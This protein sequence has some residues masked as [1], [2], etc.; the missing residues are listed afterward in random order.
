MAS[1]LCIYL[2][3]T[4]QV[5]AQDVF[6]SQACPAAF[7]QLPLYPNASLCQI[8][9]D[10]LPASLTYHANADQQTTQNF[11]LSKM[12]QADSIKTVKGRI[13]LAYN[14]AD[15]I[16]ILSQDGT[17]TQVDVLLKNLESPEE[18][19]TSVSNSANDSSA[20]VQLEE[21]SL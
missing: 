5:S 16:I 17:G 21:D 19:A 3:S 2:P 4:S 13:Q 15:I 10:D 11:Y 8:F 1:T 12:G 6:S 20:D 7:F 18:S 14:Q 9:D